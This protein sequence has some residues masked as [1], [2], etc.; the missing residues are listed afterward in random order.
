MDACVRFHVFA[1]RLSLTFSSNSLN[2]LHSWTILCVH[3]SSSGCVC[4]CAAEIILLD[5]TPLCL[6]IHRCDY[7]LHYV[8]AEQVVS[9]AC[10][11][12]DVSHLLCVF[13]GTDVLAGR[14][15]E[16]FCSEAEGTSAS[17]HRG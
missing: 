11:C 1:C 2:L 9:T 14:E 8:R 6:S 7:L 10:A 3:G 17:R 12:A 5:I 15:D 4:V 13:G 16:L